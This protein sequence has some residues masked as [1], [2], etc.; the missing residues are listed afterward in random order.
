MKTIYQ[1]NNFYEAPE[2]VR[3]FALKQQFFFQNRSP[4]PG[5][6]TEHSFYSEDVIKKIESTIGVKIAVNPM[7]NVFGRFRLS[8]G[9]DEGTT[10]VHFDRGQWAMVI[11]L[12][13]PTEETPGTAF[14]RF[15]KNG[16]SDPNQFIEQGIYSLKTDIVKHVIGPFTK[17]LDRWEII[18]DNLFLFNTAIIFRGDR[19]FHAAGPSFGNSKSTGRLTHQFFFNEK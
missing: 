13:N 17:S 11:Y 5:S 4:F 12:S 3:E 7:E 18:W 15:K 9:G 14:Y 19:T 10:K 8:L 2:R 1:I 16:I 6:Q